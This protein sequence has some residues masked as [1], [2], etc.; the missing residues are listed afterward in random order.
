MTSHPLESG[1]LLHRV[2]PTGLDDLWYPAH[3]T[4][5]LSC[6]AGSDVAAIC[7]PIW[8]EVEAQV[9]HIAGVPP[10]GAGDSGLLP[11]DTGPVGVTLKPGCGCETGPSGGGWMWLSLLYL[12]RRRIQARGRTASQ[13]ELGP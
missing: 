9:A 6:P 10:T 12:V 11:T 13:S 7:E 4:A 2:S 8:P 3:V 5:P 1:W